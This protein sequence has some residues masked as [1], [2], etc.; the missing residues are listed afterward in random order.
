MSTE[1]TIYT[2]QTEPLQVSDVCE[3]IFFP[4]LFS[5]FSNRSILVQM[6]NEKLKKKNL[7]Y[8]VV[9]IRVPTSE[10]KIW[11]WNRSKALYDWRITRL[12]CTIRHTADNR[13]PQCRDSLLL[14][15]N[16]QGKIVAILERPKGAIQI[17]KWSN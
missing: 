17:E 1:L 4:P 13:L 6:S 8:I 10:K 7:Q 14:Y 12:V 2:H 9:H 15:R 3:L 5:A 16:L 11:P